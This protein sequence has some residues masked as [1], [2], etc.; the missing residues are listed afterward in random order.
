MPA[1]LWRVIISKCDM[2]EKNILFRVSLIIKEIIGECPKIDICNYNVL[3]GYLNNLKWCNEM[4]YRFT[5]KTCEN[6]IRCG[7]LE[8]V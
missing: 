3:N 2:G 1:G 7:N 4:N 8:V 5:H 6:A